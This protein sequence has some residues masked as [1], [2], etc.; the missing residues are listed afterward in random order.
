MPKTKE[1]P[2]LTVTVETDS[3]DEVRRR[4]AALRERTAADEAALTAA[5]VQHRQ[6]GSEADGTAWSAL[7]NRVADDRDELVALEAALATGE[8]EQLEA[9][10]RPHLDAATQ[11]SHALQEDLA[12]VREGIDALRV[13]I[14]KVQGR[15]RTIVQELRAGAH[16]RVD[17]VA[18]DDQREVALSVVGMVL[19]LYPDVIRGE[20]AMALAALDRLGSRVQSLVNGRG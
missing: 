13:A 20:R 2:G 1:P 12:A 10:R 5:D 18:A 4:V 14:E 6:T 9:E 8:R 11:E 15:H 19:R 16:P 17:E 7:R 3:L